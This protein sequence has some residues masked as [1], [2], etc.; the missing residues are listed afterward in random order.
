MNSKTGSN[1][2]FAAWKKNRIHIHIRK[3]IVM[4]V[5]L[6]SH[7]MINNSSM[8]FHQCA[9]QGQQIQ[10]PRNDIP[11]WMTGKMLKLSPEKRPTVRKQILSELQTSLWRSWWNRWNKIFFYSCSSYDHSCQAVYTFCMDWFCRKGF[12]CC[13][14][15]NRLFY[16]NFIRKVHVAKSVVLV[17]ISAKECSPQFTWFPKIS[18]MQIFSQWLVCALLVLKF[19]RNIFHLVERVGI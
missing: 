18:S 11:E 17:S 1:H 14:N 13:S 19:I 6:S 4:S 5:H 10:R 16:E 2:R 15:S 7:F 9:N 12:D 3:N 8:T